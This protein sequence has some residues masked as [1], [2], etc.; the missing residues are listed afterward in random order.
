MFFIKITKTNRWNI[1]RDIIWYY[2]LLQQAKY[3]LLSFH[4]ITVNAIS[5]HHN[6]ILHIFK[7]LEMQN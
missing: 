6:L 2:F 7:K 1:L 4:I 3:F 5:L